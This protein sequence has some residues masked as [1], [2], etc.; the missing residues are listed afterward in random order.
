M[1]YKLELDENNYCTGN[2][3]T[4]GSFK[5]F[6]EVENLPVND[7]NKLQ[8][9]KLSDTSSQTDENIIESQ[10]EF[11]TEKYENMLIEQANAEIEL[12]KNN[13]LKEISDACTNTIYAG[14]DIEDLGHFS[15]T[16]HDQI[17]IS[18]LYNSAVLGI[19]TLP[20]HADGELC[21]MYTKEEIILIG[22]TAKEHVTYNTT[23]CNHINIWIRRS[24][25]I[26]EIENITYDYTLLPE[27][28]L[29][30]FLSIVEVK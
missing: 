18:N 20:Y 17:N 27:D 28:L 4:I 5:K 8:C 14:I 30:S 23:L 22:E 16:E 11:D 1:M 2:Y 6:I 15:L 21:K 13:K 7:Y 25:T 10:I 12:A 26:D 24:T 3:C 29:S 19:E 9:Y